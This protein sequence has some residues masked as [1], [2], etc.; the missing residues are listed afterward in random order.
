MK[1]SFLK[2]IFQI[3]VIKKK[4][5]KI[6]PKSGVSVDEHAYRLDHNKAS[7]FIFYDVIYSQEEEEAAAH[8]INSKGNKV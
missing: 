1:Y 8:I 7:F 5:L 4:Y 2:K 6:L 3:L